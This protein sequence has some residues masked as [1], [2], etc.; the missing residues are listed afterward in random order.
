MA[1]EKLTPEAA[2]AKKEALLAARASRAK[3]EPYK[4]YA[5]LPDSAKS[6]VD[7]HM[8]AV[9]READS[10]V[11]FTDAQRK[12]YENF[13]LLCAKHVANDHLSDSQILQP[14][15]DAAIREL[16]IMEEDL[17]P[18]GSNI[19]SLVPKICAAIKAHIQQPSNQPTV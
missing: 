1:D 15:V 17:A 8:L 7:Q 5:D 6:L 12:A 13:A 3:K 14:R 2:A 16:S 11:V 18:A 19:H 9:I 4:V 10:E